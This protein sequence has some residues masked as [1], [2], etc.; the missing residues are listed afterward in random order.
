MDITVQERAQTLIEALPYI[1]RYHGQTVL[2]KYGGN[3]M[4]DPALKEA[5]ITDVVLM[6][7]VGMRPIL[8]H[9]GGPEITDAMKRMG[10][11]AT[12]VNGLRVTDAETMEIVEM[13]LAGK[14]N[15]GI[16][17][18]INRKGGLGVG[19]SGKDAKLIVARKRPGP[20]LGFVGDVTTINPEII[21]VLV[22]QGFIP[23]ICS[24]A[25]GEAG[26]SYN[27]NADHVAGQLAAALGAVKLIMLTDVEGI[28]EDFSDKNSL[29]SRLDPDGAR[30]MIASGKVE[31]G[32][33]PKVEACLMALEGGVERAHV[34]DGRLP[35]ATLI[36]LFTDRGIGTMIA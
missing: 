11:E 26:E 17:S 5:V 33:V 31:K 4:I 30:A 1:R 36:E 6:H 34:I 19:L 9:G 14:T 35:H 22:S 12:F 28:Y 29:I 20:D 25:T 2:I 18:L 21:H 8:V 13:V 7:Y 23:V 15:K 3:A 16:V 10:K 32:M 24:V 27:V